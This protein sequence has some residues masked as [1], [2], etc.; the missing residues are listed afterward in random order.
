MDE[1]ADAV[2]RWRA[3]AIRHAADVGASVAALATSPLPVSP[4]I[5]TGSGTTGWRNATG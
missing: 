3:E 1:I 5:G 4:T 2:Q